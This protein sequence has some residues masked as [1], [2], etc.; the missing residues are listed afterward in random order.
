MDEFTGTK[1]LEDENKLILDVI[2]Q[3]IGLHA[4]IPLPHFPAVTF[5]S[6]GAAFSMN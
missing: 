5:L 3:S 4:V 2:G 1:R 6:I